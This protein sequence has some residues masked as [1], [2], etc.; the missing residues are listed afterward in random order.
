[1]LPHD[2]PQWELVYQQTQ[3]WIKAQV[4]EAMAHDL[5]CVIRQLSG[6]EPSPSAAIVSRTLI[7]TCESGARAGYDG[8]K[9]KGSKIHMAVDTL[10]SCWP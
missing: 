1:M 8:A 5:R 7:A 6:R 10:V 9:R 3:R 4:F 2:F